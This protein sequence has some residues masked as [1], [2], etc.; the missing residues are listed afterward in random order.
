MPGLTRR[1]SA[2]G[3]GSH[4]R[5]PRPRSSHTPRRG[6]AAVPGPASYK[7]ELPPT[8]YGAADIVNGNTE[9]GRHASD[10]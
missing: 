4:S 2:G 7:M 9:P 6:G 10:D 5:G 3:R 8:L 1:H